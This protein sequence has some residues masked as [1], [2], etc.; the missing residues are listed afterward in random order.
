MSRERSDNILDMD[1]AVSGLEREKRDSK[2]K[3]KMDKFRAGAG[4][5]GGAKGGGVKKEHRAS[6]NQARGG[7]SL[8]NKKP[9]AKMGKKM[10]KAN[11]GKKK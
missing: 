7:K 8:G 1:R 2:S 10:A 5:A 6:K 3:A 9:G 4:G 11:K